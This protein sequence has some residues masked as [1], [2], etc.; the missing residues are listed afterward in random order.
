MALIVFIPRLISVV[1]DYSG[2]ISFS[3]KLAVPMPF[4]GPPGTERPDYGRLISVSMEL[5]LLIPFLRY[6]VL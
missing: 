6:E 2:K 3:M 5:A 4:L 1:T